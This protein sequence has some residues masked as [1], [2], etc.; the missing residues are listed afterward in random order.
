[1]CQ[2]RTSVKQPRTPADKDHGV[3]EEVGRKPLA[4]AP[5]SLALPGKVAQEQALPEAGEH[6]I[7]LLDRLGLA[8]FLGQE[9]RVT[10]KSELL[11]RQ[12]ALRL[13]RH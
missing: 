5:S 10:E 2:K 9:I 4:G 11:L 6:G 13:S 7:S 1:V 3:P 12:A 8:P